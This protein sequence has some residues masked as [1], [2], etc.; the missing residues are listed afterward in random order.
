MKNLQLS[1]ALVFFDLETTGTDPLTDKIVELAALRIAPDDTREERSRRVNPGRPIP[2]EATAIHGIRDEDVRDA[3]PFPRIA[4][5][6][7]EWLGDAD[8]AG[9]NV[10]GFDL[11]LLERELEE[12]GLD[13]RL[14]ERRVVDAMAIFH[15]RER[16]DLKAAVRF[17]LGREHLLAHG[18]AADVAA[19]AEVLDAQFERYP[20]L[21]RSVEALDEMTRGR[22]GG[23]DR[24]GKFIWKSAEAVFSFGKHQGRTLQEV[25]LEA[26]G[27][28]EWILGSDFPGDAKDLVRRA[29]EGDFPSPPKRDQS[30]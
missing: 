6:F 28:L 3:P 12:C 14:G 2:A 4:R 1:R 11:V 16:R 5:G 13:L 23:V 29:L 24:S 21:P 15:Q 7:L 22:S 30:V 8:L 10:R 19:T 27:Y 26:P 18:A 20:D 17:Y 25:A 9:F